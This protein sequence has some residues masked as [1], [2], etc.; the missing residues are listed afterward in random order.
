MIVKSAVYEGECG[1]FY[2][3]FAMVA[4]ACLFPTSSL[5]MIPFL[6]EM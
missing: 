6:L 2:K 5:Q 4:P 1:G 3:E